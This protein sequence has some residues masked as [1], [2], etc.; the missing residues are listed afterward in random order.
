MR[1]K[2]VAESIKRELAQIIKESSDPRF[3]HITITGAE[4]TRDLKYA[5][6]FYTTMKH[7]EAGDALLKAVGYIK[8][9]LAKRLE[10]RYLPELQ[11]E[12]DKS[13][14]YGRHID[15]ILNSIKDKE[16]KENNTEI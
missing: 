9:Q 3:F 5:K 6:I 7:P 15:E 4:V 1:S 13:Y 10:I 2:R 16:V 14:E 12:E 11:F 8:S